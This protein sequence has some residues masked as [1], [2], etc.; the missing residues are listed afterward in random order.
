LARTRNAPK[1]QTSQTY[2]DQRKPQIQLVDY[3]ANGNARPLYNPLS[4]KYDLKW[5]GNQSFYRTPTLVS[6]WATAPFLHNNSLGLYNGDPS[7]KG[8]IEAYTDAMQKMLWPEKRL[9]VGSIKVTSH[10]T[11][12]PEIFP[13]LESKLKF[14]NGLDLKLM[15]LPKGTPVNLMLSIIPKFAPELIEAYIKGVLK[16]E[17]RSRFKGLFNRRREAGMVAFK[18]KL[19]ELNTCPDFIEDRGHLFGSHLSDEQKRALI[20]Y[21]KYF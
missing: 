7:V 17:P 14:L 18:Q 1:A 9:G 3:D 2:K 11:S 21:V 5:T 15:M 10:E 13:G 12:L 4:E 6:I 8:R 16:G 19:L 20:E